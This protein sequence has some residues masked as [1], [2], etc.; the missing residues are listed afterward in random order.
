[1]S[2]NSL[3]N[4]KIIRRRKRELKKDIGYL[5]KELNKLKIQ[6]LVQTL[7]LKRLKIIKSQNTILEDSTSETDE[8]YYQNYKSKSCRSEKIQDSKKNYEDIFYL[9]MEV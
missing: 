4:L 7:N 6:E 8:I 5:L 9:E 1:M 2:N 3:N